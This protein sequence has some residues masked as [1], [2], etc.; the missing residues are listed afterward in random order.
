MTIK[1]V[2]S[3]I[4]DNYK[5]IVQIID[6]RPSKPDVAT[7]NIFDDADFEKGLSTNAIILSPHSVNNILQNYKQVINQMINSKIEFPE[8]QPVRKCYLTCSELSSY[9]SSTTFN[10]GGQKYNR[11][12]TC[13]TCLL[14][15]CFV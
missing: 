3:V 13:K 2:S 14:A 10:W 15:P 7:C 1:V 8:L 11:K 5:I 4:S 9:S 12:Y 6:N